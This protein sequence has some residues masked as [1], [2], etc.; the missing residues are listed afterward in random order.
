MLDYA[1]CLAMRK[2]ILVFLNE[3]KVIPSQIS[4]IVF[5]RV[6]VSSNAVL[7]LVCNW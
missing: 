1:Y 4:N 7:L 2:T 3:G 6:V 5:R